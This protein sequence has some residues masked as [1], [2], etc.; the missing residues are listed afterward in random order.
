[1]NILN[2]IT[3][4]PELKGFFFYNEKYKIVTVYGNDD[5]KSTLWLNNQKI[6]ELKLPGSIRNWHHWD[7]GTIGEVTFK[8]TGL[9]LPILKYNKG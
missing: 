7:Q 3:K 6:E 4:V 8:T 5:N 2:K 9:N 1:L